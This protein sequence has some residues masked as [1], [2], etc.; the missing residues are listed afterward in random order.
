M[1]W[2]LLA[3][4]KHVRAEKGGIRSSTWPEIRR[5]KCNN[6]SPGFRFPRDQYR[7]WNQRPLFEHPRRTSQQG[8]GWIYSSPV[9]LAGLLSS[10]LPGGFV[11]S[12]CRAELATS[13]ARLGTRLR[14]ATHMEK[15]R[16]FVMDDAVAAAAVTAHTLRCADTI[17]ALALVSS[18]PSCYAVPPD[19]VG[20]Q[21]ALTFIPHSQQLFATQA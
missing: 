5:G 3:N 1:P 8:T 2:K 12:H 16:S 17:V 13:Q 4:A 21:V 11:Q 9:F 6:T 7:S 18:A 15:T 20:W 19:G 10:G 14:I